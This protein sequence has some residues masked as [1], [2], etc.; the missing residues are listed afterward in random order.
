MCCC[1]CLPIFKDSLSQVSSRQKCTKAE[2][3]D[4]EGMD[5]NWCDP[6][7]TGS[8]PK[9][10][11]TNKQTNTQSLTVRYAIAQLCRWI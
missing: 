7:S 2:N 11:N 6:V 5:F 1:C 4:R 10:N 3:V 9:R 8:P